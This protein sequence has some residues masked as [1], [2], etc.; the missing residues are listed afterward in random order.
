[1]STI[2]TPAQSEPEIILEQINKDFAQCCF[3][4]GALVTLPNTGNI[5]RFKWA[6]EHAKELS[7]TLMAA[8][9]QH[10]GKS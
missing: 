8:Y 9:I 6:A 10:G 3:D 7:I 5:D 2:N 4:Y 1:M